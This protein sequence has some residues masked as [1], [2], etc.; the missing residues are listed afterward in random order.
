MTVKKKVI[1]IALLN[2]FF[3]NFFSI[4][5]NFFLLYFLAVSIN[6]NL[7]TGNIKKK[8]SNILRKYLS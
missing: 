6:K 8:K 2:D 7:Y 4:S 1:A 3:F 5:E